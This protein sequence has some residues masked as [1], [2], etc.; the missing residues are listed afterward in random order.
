M[1]F[2]EFDWEK[3]LLEC[4]SSTEYCA[5]STVDK[6]GS[7]VNPVFFAWDKQWNLYF[8]S[9]MSSRHMQN[10][11]KDPRTSVAIFST[12]QQGDVVGIQMQGMAKFVLPDSAPE[13]IEECYATYYNR[14]GH[15]PDVKHYKNDSSWIYVKITPSQV[16]Y[17]DTRFFEEVR[18][19]VPLHIFQ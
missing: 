17:F 19:E 7:W 10:L 6:D 14:A 15:G 3:Y 8:I 13:E 11:K 4:M 18:Q 1:E 5:I 16:F 9:Q 2:R 12:A